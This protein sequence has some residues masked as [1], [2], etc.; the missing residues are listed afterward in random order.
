MQHYQMAVFSAKVQG[1]E[2]DI[3]KTKMP[4]LQKIL[5]EII[6]QIHTKVEIVFSAG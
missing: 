5:F 4:L 1:I 2:E 3:S 6:L